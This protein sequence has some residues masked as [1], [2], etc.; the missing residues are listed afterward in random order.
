MKRAPWIKVLH[1]LALAYFSS[2][3]GSEGS[4]ADSGRMAGW[5]Y[6]GMGGQLTGGALGNNPPPTGASG[7]TGTSAPAGGAGTSNGGTPATGGNSAG[8]GN[9][10]PT[11]G[12][13]HQLANWGGMAANNP[14]HHG[15]VYFLGHAHKDENGVEC[16]SC[17]GTNYEGGTG[18]ACTTC[19]AEWRSSCSYCHGSSAT[20]VAPPRGIYDE[21]ST[22]SLAVGRHSAHLSD[23]SSHPAFAC[24]TCHVVPPSNDVD[25]TLSYQPSTDL[26]SAG[27]HG[28]VVLTSAV[29]GMTWKVDATSGS[30]V[31]ARGSCVGGCH[32]DGRGG[33]PATTPLWAGGSWTTGCGNCHAASPKTGYHSHALS[34]GGKCADCHAGATGTSYAAAT[35]LN[36]TIDYLG[37]VSGQGMTLKADSTC[38][39]G[40]RCNGTC[41]GNSDGHNNKC[42]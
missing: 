21:T 6:D 15:R 9:P 13:Y 40:V 33:P 32:S 28:D 5:S 20:M 30:P 1:L 39:N 18:P 7:S 25:H 14:N 26:T 42:W 12:Q 41:H 16:S 8:S 23:G 29:P 24:A 17:H 2:S 34:K 4:L 38:A 11:S 10:N 35:H 3:C 36:G 22:A 27:H 31:S 19:H 37:T